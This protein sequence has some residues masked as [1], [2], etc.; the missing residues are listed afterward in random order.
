MRLKLKRR[1]NAMAMTLANLGSMARDNN[2][3][4]RLSCTNIPSSRYTRSE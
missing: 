4:N 1:V 2:H 3:V